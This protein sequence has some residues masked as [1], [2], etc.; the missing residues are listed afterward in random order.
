MRYLSSLTKRLRT[1]TTRTQHARQTPTHPPLSGCA[2]SKEPLRQQ[3]LVLDAQMHELWRDDEEIG[4]GPPGRDLLG[5]WRAGNDEMS[6][7]PLWVIPHV[8]PQGLTVPRA[9]T[10]HRRCE[11]PPVCCGQPGGAEDEVVEQRQC[12]ARF[13]DGGREGRGGSVGRTRTRTLA[14]ALPP[15]VLGRTREMMPRLDTALM[16]GVHQPLLHQTGPVRQDLPPLA[17]T[18]TPPHHHMRHTLIPPPS[19]GRL[20]A[21]TNTPPSTA[22]YKGSK[23]PLICS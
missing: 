14:G 15:R 20:T 18:H 6:G 21:S 16:K 23:R 11:K 9:V 13:G 5:V 1:T 19:T 8:Y 3:I 17:R 10:L 12:V 4:V 7:L 2:D 22:G